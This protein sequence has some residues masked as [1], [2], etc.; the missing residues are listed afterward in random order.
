R[1]LNIDVNRVEDRHSEDASPR[2]NGGYQQRQADAHRGAHHRNDIK[3]PREETQRVSVPDMQR[4]VGDGAGYSK[5]QHQ[6]PL[7]QQPFAHARFGA[8]QG[9]VEAM[10]MLEGEERQKPAVGYVALEAE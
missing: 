6:A 3:Q 5:D 1:V 8:A 4:Q 10:A 7:T 2:I 9:S